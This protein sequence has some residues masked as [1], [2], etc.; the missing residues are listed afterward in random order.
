MQA[1]EQKLTQFFAEHLPLAGNM[2]IEVT[3][4][5]GQQLQLSAPIEPNIND[6]LTAFGGSL[7]C[8]AVL[9]CWGMA[10]LQTEEAGINCN[11]VVARAEI[12]YLRPVSTDVF[13]AVCEIEA[14]GVNNLLTE[15]SQKGKAKIA[16]SATIMQNDKIAVRF[17]GQYAI[18]PSLV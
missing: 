18:L 10:Y 2:G 3:Y 9:S 6:K 17:Q 11:L 12:D 5:D 13:T 1:I 4:Y 7:Y 16:L 15:F 8:L 14:A